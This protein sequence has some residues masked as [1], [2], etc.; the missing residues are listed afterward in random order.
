M[1][2]DENLKIDVVKILDRDILLLV[3]STDRVPM[4]RNRSYLRGRLVAVDESRSVGLGREI[5][6]KS[7]ESKAR[8]ICSIRTRVRIERRLFF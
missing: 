6:A 3:P 5:A 4:E 7:H 1:F 8:R 2:F